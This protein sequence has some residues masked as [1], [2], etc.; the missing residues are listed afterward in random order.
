MWLNLKVLNIFVQILIGLE[1]KLK[2]NVTTIFLF[3]SD[4]GT[5]KKYLTSKLISSH[6]SKLSEG[7][8]IKMIFWQLFGTPTA[9]APH[10]CGV[11][12]EKTISHKENEKEG[13]FAKQ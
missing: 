2:S 4:I 7:K 8:P 1:E 13:A 9:L 11:H 10:Q 12:I 3:Q 5:S 6:N